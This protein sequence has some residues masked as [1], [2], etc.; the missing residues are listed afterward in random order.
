MKLALVLSILSEFIGGHK[1]C[2]LLNHNRALVL[3]A[4]D[5]YHLPFG[6]LHLLSPHDLSF[7]PHVHALPLWLAHILIALLAPSPSTRRAMK[8]MILY[9]RIRLAYRALASN[10]LFLFLIRVLHEQ[11][12]FLA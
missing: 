11:E 12:Q 8:V 1:S 3:G 6:C 7:H 5:H 10:P 4:V 2:T 9:F